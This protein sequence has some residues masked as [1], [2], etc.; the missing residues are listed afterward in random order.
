M[1]FSPFIFISIFYA[2]VGIRIVWQIVQRRREIFDRTFTP[3]DR[4]MVD[5]AAFFVL[6]PVSVILHELGHAITIWTLGGQ[7]VDYGFYGF[8]GFV[9]FYPEEFTA[10]ERILIAAAGS[11]VNLVLI[12]IALAVVFMRKPPLRAAYNELLLQFIFISGVNAFIVYPILDVVSNF[13]G[14]W[15]QMYDGGVPALSLAIGVIH[16][17]ILGS[18]Y[19]LYTNPRMKARTAT[20]TDVPPGYER[21]MLG[22]IQ[23]SKLDLTTLSPAE[24]TLRESAERVAGGWGSHVETGVQRFNG[25]SAVTVAW[26]R[27]H[28]QHLIAARTF[29]NGT[30]DLIAIPTAPQGS[31]TPP[32]PRQLHRWA[33]TPTTDE[34]TIALRLAMESIDHS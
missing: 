17:A 34:L 20:L 16:L 12:L 26:R 5:Q 29:A 2:I 13:N 21:R 31:P 27:G 22:G 28:V 32:V 7:V 8:A 19:W 30:T 10:A 6:V 18:G 3:F 15:R 23:P 14:D 9:S 24:R 4:S 25:G 33:A 1:G 11:L